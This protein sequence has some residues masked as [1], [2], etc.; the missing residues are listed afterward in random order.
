MK[1]CIVLLVSISFLYGCSCPGNCT[2]PAGS[3]AID[4]QAGSPAAIKMNFSYVEGIVD[5][6][7]IEG[8]AP[9][10]LAVRIVSLRPGS[11]AES[12]VEPGQEMVVVPAMKE[13]AKLAPLRQARRGDRFSGSLSRSG[14][15][16]W[17]LLDATIR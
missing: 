7:M 5:S 14:D 17:L 3:S 16:Q 9:V 2:I 15:G 10:R 1:H 4:R 8:E 11:A 12:L 13:E 6:V